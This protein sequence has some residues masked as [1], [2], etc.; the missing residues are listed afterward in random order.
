MSGCLLGTKAPAF[1]VVP[2]TSAG[3]M[4]AGQLR[5]MRCYSPR[6]ARVSLSCPVLGHSCVP[7]QG[8]CLR[9]RSYS[10]GM[11]RVIEV[12]DAPTGSRDLMAEAK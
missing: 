3:A 7:V 6:G 10:S 12:R 2:R 11:A 9:R 4:Q 8:S 1:E 5:M